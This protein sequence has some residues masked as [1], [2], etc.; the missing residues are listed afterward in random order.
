MCE[1]FCNNFY[2]FSRCILNISHCL[3]TTY[4]HGWE[5]HR[6]MYMTVLML[7]SLLICS[8]SSL[9]SM[10]RN[11]R[12][13]KYLCRKCVI[14][15]RAWVFCRWLI[16]GNY[17]DIFCRISWNY[18]SVNP[19]DEKRAIFTISKVLLSTLRWHGQKNLIC[20]ILNQKF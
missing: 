4:K 20:Y 11:M 19:L 10:K 15:I 5:H 17:N 13:N 6:Y 16:N 1:I 12:Y 9:N 7:V 14:G 18:S 3:C 8:S 2:Y